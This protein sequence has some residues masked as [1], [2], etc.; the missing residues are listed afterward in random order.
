MANPKQRKTKLLNISMNGILV[1]HLEKQSTGP[2]KFIYDQSWLEREQSLPISRQFPLRE[3]PFSGQLVQ[4]YFDNLLPDDPRVKERLAV[5]S[6]AD[7]TNA[8]DILAA[9]GRDCIGALQFHEEEQT[10]EANAVK[11]QS[12]S[13]NKI[14]QTLRDLRINPLGIDLEQDFRISLAGAQSKTALLKIDDNWHLPE[15][16]TPTTHIIK[17]AIG[18]VPGGPDLTLSVENEWFCLKIL[19]EFGLKTA[20]AEIVNFEDVRALV[21]KR[22]DRRWSGKKLYRL[23]QEDMC[24][25]LGVGPSKKYESDGGP[26]IKNILSLLNESDRR[27][28]DRKDFMKAMLP[29]TSC[30]PC[31]IAVA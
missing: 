5:L 3:V 20:E 21:V 6:K 27:D 10:T 1:G 2:L 25:A 17:P 24:Q 29:R 31:E 18:L 11:G 7:G 8:F 15:R 30:N 23:P 12:I 19:H 28:I 22:F 13:E 16:S 4:D 9:I 14:A 26:G